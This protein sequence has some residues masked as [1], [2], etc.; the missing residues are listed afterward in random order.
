MK[1]WPDDPT[2][3]VSF[4]ELVGPIRAAFEQ[5]YM[6]ELDEP[7][8]TVEY[9]GYDIGQREKACCLSPDEILTKDYL[10]R[11]LEDQ[12]RDPLDAILMLAFQLGVEQ[13]RRLTQA[14]VEHYKGLFEA[15][16]RMLAVA[17]NA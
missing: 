4:E 5:L 17:K 16:R 7:V 12:G 14:D 8:Q 3:T 13:G 11:A 9:D 10:K 6:Y 2:E 15:Y 1:P